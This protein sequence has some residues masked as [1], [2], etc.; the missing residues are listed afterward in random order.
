MFSKYLFPDKSLRE[1]LY[2]IRDYYNLKKSKPADKNVLETLL[3]LKNYNKPKQLILKNG[4]GVF[5]SEEK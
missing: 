3:E 4:W 5:Y 2:L 1:K